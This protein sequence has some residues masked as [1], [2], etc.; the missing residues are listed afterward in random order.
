MIRNASLAD[1]VRQNENEQDFSKVFEQL[2][3]FVN[4][5]LPYYEELANAVVYSHVVDIQYIEHEL[6]TMLSLCF[7][8]K[9]L[10]LYKKILRN[11]IKQYPDTVKFYIDSYYSMYENGED[12]KE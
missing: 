9:I 4:D 6:D 8:D 2:S 7:D 5:R 12:N 1:Q 3:V 11:L 10:P